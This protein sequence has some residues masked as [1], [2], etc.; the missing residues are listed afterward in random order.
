MESGCF[1]NFFSKTERDKAMVVIY[2]KMNWDFLP[3]I[4]KK[5][6]EKGRK[7]GKKKDTALEVLLVRYDLGL[8]H[9]IQFV[10]R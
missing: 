5:G 4:T 7:K 8:Q 10:A 2:S 1:L 9:W 3:T 6:K